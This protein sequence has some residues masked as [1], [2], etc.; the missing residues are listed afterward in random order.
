QR[1]NRNLLVFL[2]PDSKR[3]EELLEATRHYLAWTWVN[4]RREELNLP[5]E[6]VRAVVDNR[7]RNDQAVTARLS[8]AYHWVLVP[9]QPDPK[10]PPV[11]T[12]EKADGATDRL[13][14]R[15]TDK[16]TRS[17][18]LATVVAARTIRLDLDQKLPEVWGRGHLSVGEL[19]GYY[20]RYPYL[21]RLRDRSVFE[22]AVS[23]VL[24]TIT[25]ELDGFALATGFDQAVGRYQG[26]TL[27]GGDARFGQI[28]DSTLLVTPAVARAQHDA[29]VAAARAAV[30]A[31]EETS[32]AAPGGPFTTAGAI[33]P[34]GTFSE[35]QSAL[36][37]AAG[38]TPGESSRSGPENTRFF[39][40]YRLD[41]ERYGRDLT[42]LSQEILQQLAATDG[43]QLDITVEVHARR[44]AG[45]PP[46]RVRVVLENASTLKFEQAGFEQD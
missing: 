2:A 11:M 5:P 19:W 17:G 35:H 40:V 36:E 16:L 46:D 39:G 38:A 12:V 9:D 21:T 45:F 24:A 8:Q 20:R 34:G 41:P 37:P 28:T 33:V 6:Q 15:V 1:V 26:L 42:R 30:G 13:A 27:P 23:S 31:P 25:W 44:A 3:A 22:D 14:E 7:N 29:E 43:V 10:R 4:D 18:L 32:G